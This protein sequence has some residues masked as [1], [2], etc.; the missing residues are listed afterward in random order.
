MKM[1]III[2]VIL[3]FIILIVNAYVKCHEC[4][5]K[6]WAKSCSLTWDGITNNI[7]PRILFRLRIF[8]TISSSGRLRGTLGVFK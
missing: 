7:F 1:F 2:A 4:K 3:L 5:K 8:S 6:E